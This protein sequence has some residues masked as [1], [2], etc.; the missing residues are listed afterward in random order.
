MEEEW[1]LNEKGLK[2]QKTTLTHNIFMSCLFVFGEF[3]PDGIS[4]IV[5]FISDPG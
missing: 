3:G 4:L 2:Y 1:V 5:K